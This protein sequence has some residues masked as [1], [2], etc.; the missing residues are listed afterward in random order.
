MSASSTTAAATATPAASTEA[1]IALQITHGIHDILRHFCPSFLLRIGSAN[2]SALVFAGFS[3]PA[4]Q[5][6]EER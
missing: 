5:S 2:L 3:C 4:A 6:D 1:D